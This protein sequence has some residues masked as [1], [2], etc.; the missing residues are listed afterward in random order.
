L[1]FNTENTT[2]NFAPETSTL[3]NTPVQNTQFSQYYFSYLYNL[4]NL[5][6]R[7]VNVK[8]NLPTS[9]I[10][11]LQLNDRL[12]IR[13]KRYII[14]EMQS[15]LNTGDVDFQLLLDFRPII[16]STVPQPKTSTAGGDVNYAVN[17]PNGAYEATLS[18]ENSDVTFSVNPVESSQIIQIGIPAGSAG[19]VYTIRIT[20]SYINGTSTEEFFNI[21]Q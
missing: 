20:Y 14:N 3:L 13:D 8:T 11:N 4:Y 2:L 10:T 15:N 16:N 5:K 21:L 18:S 17:L 1:L 7:L 19:T 6:Q 9:L 12:V